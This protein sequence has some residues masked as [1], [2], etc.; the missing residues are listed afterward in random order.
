MPP[1]VMSIGIDDITIERVMRVMIEMIEM[2][3][4]ERATND[5]VSSR[6]TMMGLEEIRGSDESID[7]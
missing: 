5:D 4:S 1:Y 3:A 7:H 6:E 2:I